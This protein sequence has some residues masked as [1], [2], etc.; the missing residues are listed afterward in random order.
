MSCGSRTRSWRRVHERTK[1]LSQ[2][3]RQLQREVTVRASVEADLEKS[4]AL[5][6]AT[7]ESSP[8]GLV[9]VDLAGRIV[10]S[11]QQW[12]D[13]WG[14]AEDHRRI[15]AGRRSWSTSKPLL[16]EPGHLKFLQTKQRNGLVAEGVRT[17]GLT[18]GRVLECQFRPQLLGGRSVGR[19]WNFRDTTRQ[20]RT[21]E[22]QAR[23]EQISQGHREY[24]GRAVPGAL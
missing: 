4:L 24:D 7:V 15:V 17:I 3:N 16:K 11:N 19:V 10:T 1:E 14:I 22:A 23:S 12:L 20:R 6:R 13:L 2:S 9:A 18:D 8:G 21:E 5:F